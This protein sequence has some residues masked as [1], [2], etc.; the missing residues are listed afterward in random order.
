M[1]KAYNNVE[2]LLKLYKKGELNESQAY[3]LITE[4]IKIQIDDNSYPFITNNKNW[5]STSTVTDE[6]V[7]TE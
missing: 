3:D 2:I 1:S 6:S 4:Q 7:P 5:T